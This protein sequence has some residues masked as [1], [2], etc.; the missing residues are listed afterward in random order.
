MSHDKRTPGVEHRFVGKDLP[1]REHYAQAAALVALAHNWK[2]TYFE[3]RSL[4]NAMTVV[5]GQQ[6]TQE[7]REAYAELARAFERVMVG[8]NGR[9][10]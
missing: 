6:L 2:Q 3:S 4:A 10:V 5:L 9:K 1:P 7:Q 8:E